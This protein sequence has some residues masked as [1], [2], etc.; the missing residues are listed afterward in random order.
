MDRIFNLVEI[1]G[2]QPNGGHGGDPGFGQILQVT[3]VHVPT[4]GRRRVAQVAVAFSGIDPSGE[5]FRM[6]LVVPREAG[7]HEIECCPIRLFFPVR[8][9]QMALAQAQGIVQWLVIHFPFGQILAF[10]KSQTGRHAFEGILCGLLKT[11]F[12]WSTRV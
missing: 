4:Q 2:G 8:G 10:G 1:L 11:M 3:L 6:L 12:S 7:D 9:L 5:G